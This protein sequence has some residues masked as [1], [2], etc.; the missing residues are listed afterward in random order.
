MMSCDVML[1]RN[2]IISRITS[3][4]TKMLQQVTPMFSDPSNMPHKFMDFIPPLKPNFLKQVPLISNQIEPAVDDKSDLKERN[5]MA[6]QKWRK[7]KDQYL[8]ELEQT[9]D[10]LRQQV[11][12]L[13]SE[14][15]SLKVENAVLERELQFFQ[16][17]MSK[18]MNQNH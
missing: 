6:A 12:D 15:Q 10:N 18:I 13:S 4:T 3:F 14:A 17:F 7:K 9:N 5:R 2:S 8:S 11:L 16:S 1:T